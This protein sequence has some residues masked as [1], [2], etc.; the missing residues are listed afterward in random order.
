MASFLSGGLFAAL[1]VAFSAV[2]Y[3]LRKEKGQGI[4]KRIHV[5]QRKDS[6]Y[7]ASLLNPAQPEKQPQD[8][9]A[10]D[11]SSTVPPSQR[12][13]LNSIMPYW[14]LWKSLI[15]TF[16][17]R[18]GEMGRML[19]M[20]VSYLDAEGS[21]TT[22]CGFSVDEIKALG[23]FPD[24]AKLSGMPLP[25]PYQNFDISKALPRPYRPFRWAYHQTM[26]RWLFEQ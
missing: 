8:A 9:K 20:G 1:F 5:R 19:P 16:S 2:I 24:Y 25:K 21:M 3:I 6:G 14:K 11:Y 26:C 22:P 18:P 4:K 23:D 10:P 17:S 13:T 7:A 12:S 15:K